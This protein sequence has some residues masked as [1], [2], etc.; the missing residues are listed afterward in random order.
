MTSTKYESYNFTAEGHERLDVFLARMMPDFSRSFLQK[1]IREGNIEIDGV[2]QVK[3]GFQ[4]HSNHKI[5]AMVPSFA[6][7]P[8]GDMEV[9]YEDADVVVLNKPAGV[10]TH[11]KG[12][13]SDEFTVGE[14]MRPRTTDGPETNRPGIVHRLDRD[15]S[16]V[17]IAAKT[18]DAKRW[19]QKQFSTRNVK[20]TYIA[21]VEGR[22]KDPTALIQLPIE[23]NPK[24][25]QMFRVGGN[26]K[27]AET[28][29]ETLQ[30]FTHTTLLRLK[31]RTGRT[32]QL[33]V[34]MQYLHCPIVGDPVYGKPE[35]R[36]G[37]MFLHAAELE[38]TLPS[39]ERKVFVVP[40]PSELQ[41]YLD[42]LQ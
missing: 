34:H 3:S 27:P 42:S 20:K 21:L 36:L 32:H 22:P 25:P 33:R 35:P 17:I 39:R 31:P 30:S 16:G 10:L 40:L 28:T 41:N 4:L 7:T 11:A 19:L 38:L 1:L 5:V 12:A 14:F 24:K 13:H 29:Y 2:A 9:I 26:G 37:R 23:R 15:T 6:E 8:T 18:S